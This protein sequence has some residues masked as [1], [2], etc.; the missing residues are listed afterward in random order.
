MGGKPSAPRPMRVRVQIHHVSGDAY[1]AQVNLRTIPSATVTALLDTCGAE[2]EHCTSI[3]PT[4]DVVT[5]TGPPQV[6]HRLNSATSA[7]ILWTIRHPAYPQPCCNEAEFVPFVKASST[8]GN[9]KV[10][11]G[12]HVD[13]CFEHAHT[14]AHAPIRGAAGHI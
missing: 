4:D 2:K 8:S 11:V 7:N 10:G 9:D 6:F 1:V 3:D 14:H 5:I 12:N 13:V